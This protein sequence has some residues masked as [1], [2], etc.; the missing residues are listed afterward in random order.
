MSKSLDPIGQKFGKLFVKDSLSIPGKQHKY[1]KCLCDCGIIKNV[2]KDVILKGRAKSCG[3]SKDSK[4]IKYD[5]ICE[6]CL[7]PY[8]GSKIQK[9]CC[10]KCYKNHPIQI[11]NNRLNR[12]NNYYKDL[13]KSRKYTRE[14]AAKSLRK[15][16]G[17]PLDLPRMKNISGK[18]YIAKSGYK[19]FG[20]KGHPLSNIHGRVAEHKL[21]MFNHIGRPFKKG[22]N[23]HHING[24]RHDNRIENLELWSKS[25][26]SG[27]RIEDKIQWAKEFLEE[28][29]YLV[30]K[31]EVKL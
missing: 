2:R 1:L 3:C 17:L 26:P 16:K 19:Y 14:W 4:N 13:E 31:L 8:L 24:I 5:K 23:V 18:G 9:F 25:Q 12:K 20:I 15:K 6:T 7:E 10:T 22:E 11:K 21:V 27:Q 28:Y 30:T 29:G